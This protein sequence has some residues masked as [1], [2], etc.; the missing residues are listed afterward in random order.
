MC[1]LANP[2]TEQSPSLPAL[3]RMSH[4]ELRGRRD[5]ARRLIED[6]A[7][8][9]ASD[10]SGRPRPLELD[11]IPLVIPASEWTGLERGLSQRARLLDALLNDLYGDRTVI[12]RGLL[13]AELVV[14]HPGFAPPVD[15]VPAR[16]FL[17]AADLGRDGSGEWRVV[18]DRTGAPVGCGYAMAVR[19]VTARALASLH[20]ETD[21]RRLREFFDAMR[22]GLLE[23]AAG[24][25]EL[26]RVVVLTT[27][28]PNESTFD[29]AFTAT[30]LGFPV[31]HA[32]ELLVRGG[33][34]WLRTTEREEPVDVVVRRVEALLA[35]PL[36]L[37]SSSVGVP[38]LVE[39]IRHCTVT[40][41]NPVGAGVLENPALG[42]FLDGLCPALLGE[43]LLLPSA[44]TWWC[45][46]EAG[47]SVVRAH[48][49][50]L[51]LARMTAT[52][53][54]RIFT[55]DL[56]DED[57]QRLWADIERQP[58]AWSAQERLPMLTAE[59]VT[60]DAL[61]TRQGV[62]RTFTLC[63][64]SGTNVL[65]GG[66]ARLA[67]EEGADHVGRLSESVVKDV[68]VLADTM[69]PEAST[70][71]A[72]PPAATVV[73]LRRT[74]PAPPTSPT[75][76]RTVPMSTPVPLSSRAAED[77]YWF[78]RYAERAESTARLLVVADDLVEDHLRRPG[79]AGHASMRIVIDAIDAVTSVHRDQGPRAG[80]APP[81]ETAED[82]RAGSPQRSSE[83]EDPVPH[84][85]TLVFD[86][87]RRGT[88][89]YSARRAARAAGAV[90]EL[91]SFDTWLVLSRLER[92]LADPHSA[93]LQSVL[94]GVVESFLALA[95]MGAESLVRDAAWAF[96]DAGR[97]VERAQ[98][99]VRL[100]RQ[101]MTTHRPVR[102]GRPVVE[103]VLRSRES[104]I[105]YRRRLGENPATPATEIA[106][107]LLLVDAANPRSV[108]YQ[109]DRL[110]EDLA[111][112]PSWRAD[113]ALGVPGDLLA[114]LDTAEVTRDR[115]RLASALAELEV[116]L[117]RLSGALDATYFRHPTPQRAIEEPR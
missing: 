64:S 39:A 54:A 115:D 22:T 107:D 66:L 58:W 112:A 69:P 106:L 14:G 2:S 4:G 93:D 85:R 103:A 49:D 40:V 94:A 50:D 25:S 56:T 60:N 27:T 55:R 16:L 19:R 73:P 101:T 114:S 99:T 5:V 78:G 65:P 79:T 88:V 52:P 95:G 8:V 33:R 110:H 24:T 59:V 74:S 42:A 70:A 21:L 43:D 86:G 53:C 109:L 102:I 83:P 113:A 38:G 20:R 116:S 82:L 96:F 108:L 17:T 37:G 47:R 44:P 51:V 100:L 57:R 3:A 29:E 63:D 1:P 30:L 72:D 6:D 68:W 36:D 62:L 87:D 67:A 13:P 41:V 28:E 31:V 105:S 77:L 90:R 45:G 46:D 9:V 18:A 34:V 15:G 71:S 10:P 76:R 11:P 35:D 48:L 32:D 12:A 91:L 111:H 7:V 80:V 92:T 81:N 61:S 117:R 23:M 89:H 97:R 26:P 104:L 75:T 98:E 84:L